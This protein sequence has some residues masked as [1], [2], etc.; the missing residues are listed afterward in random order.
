[1]RGLF[2]LAESGG[3]SSSWCVGLS[4]LRPLPLRSTGSR[5]AG[6]RRAGS[7]VV[8]HGPSCSVACGIFPD[9]GSK[10]CVPCIGRRILNHCATREACEAF[11]CCLQPLPGW[12]S[13][14]LHLPLPFPLPSPVS[15]GTEESSQG[16]SKQPMGRPWAGNLEARVFL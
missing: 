16:G 10:P 2:P 3:H 8:A 1:M 12:Q 14:D 5:R 7:V 6:S 4:L 11:S 9:Q 15:S 13:P